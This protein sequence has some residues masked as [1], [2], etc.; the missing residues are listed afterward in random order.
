VQWLQ[1]PGRADVDAIDVHQG[2][3]RTGAVPWLRNETFM[4]AIQI[5]RDEHRALAAVLHGLRYLVSGTRD[6]GAPPSFDVLSAML[7]YIDAF[8]ERFHHPKEDRYLFPLVRARAP[9]SGPT[10]DLLATEHH[11]GAEKIRDLQ[12]AFAR[13]RE[14]GAAEFAAFGAAVEAYATFEAAHMRRE[15]TEVLSLAQA[16]LTPGD[17]Q[18]I[19]DAFT[20]HTDPLLGAAPGM[21]WQQLFSRIVTLAPA[22]IGVGPATP[23][24]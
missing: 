14:G 23:A 13:Y 12:Q 7:Y 17:W 5:I 3:I 8:P 19:D 10:L 20:G 4:K 6:R 9:Q 16:H 2:G 15:E 22:P 18:A 1:D 11:A 21:R 24:A